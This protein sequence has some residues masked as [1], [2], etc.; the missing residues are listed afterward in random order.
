MEHVVTF[1][2]PHRTTQS[3][4]AAL[5]D[6]FASAFKDERLHFVRTGVWCCFDNVTDDDGVHLYR[7]EVIK[8]MSDG[9]ASNEMLRFVEKAL[10]Q[11]PDMLPI[12]TVR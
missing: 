10:E 5:S 8:Q 12:P 1:F 3:A 4:S 11:R 2:E 7:E 6:V 9:A